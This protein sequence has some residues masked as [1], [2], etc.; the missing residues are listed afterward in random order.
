MAEEAAAAAASSSTTSLSLRFCAAA[1]AAALVIA[2]AQTTLCF[3]LKP[4]GTAVC[5]STKAASLGI[6]RFCTGVM[7][8]V[9][10]SLSVR[11]EVLLL[12]S[13]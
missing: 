9:K 1:A 7:R 11:C 2:G 10:A 4:H 6:W 3:Q 8:E 13:L 12:L 5:V